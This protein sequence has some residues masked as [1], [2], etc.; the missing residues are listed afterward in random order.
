MNEQASSLW[1]AWNASPEIRQLAEAWIKKPAKKWTNE[2]TQ[3]ATL[4]RAAPDKALSTIFAI[5]QLTD[6]A[7][8][9]G[10]LGA[11]RFEEFL[12]VRGEAYIDTIHSVALE[13]K[14]LREVLDHVRQ[15]PMSQRVWQTIKMLKQSEFS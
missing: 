6:D 12:G 15:G 8:I 10:A 9:L 13:H 3:L 11:G 1:N 7:T 5:M 2:D 14:R 4:F